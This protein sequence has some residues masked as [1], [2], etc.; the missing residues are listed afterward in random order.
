MYILQIRRKFSSTNTTDLSFPL[1]MPAAAFV[2][3]EF[4]NGA[5]PAKVFSTNFLSFFTEL[6]NVAFVP[7]SDCLLKYA[8]IYLE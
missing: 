7:F 5:K 1:L 4:A 3:T 6:S 8:F 2:S